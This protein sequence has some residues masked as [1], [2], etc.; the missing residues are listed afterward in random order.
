M[1]TVIFI[2]LFSLATLSAGD[3]TK[4]IYYPPLRKLPADSPKLIKI[5]SELALQSTQSNQSAL[6]IPTKRF[7]ISQ[8]V[9][10]SDYL[11]YLTNY[12]R[13]VVKLELM[14]RENI[15]ADDTWIEI[16]AK[17]K[18]VVYQYRSVLGAKMTIPTWKE[19]VIPVAPAVTK[20]SILKSLKNGDTYSIDKTKLKM[21]QCKTCT[22]SGK[23]FD[24]RS[25]SKKKVCKKC[26]GRGKI[27]ARV[28]QR[29]KL[30]W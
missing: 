17:N 9:N 19:V 3:S 5:L 10:G 16:T 28:I 6:N 20:E 13:Q 1:P 14:K 12:E 30:K 24:A 8:H 22:G 7:K 29:I 23:V 15:I 2:I 27:D 25:A 11:A 4:I 21:M 26:G 18:G